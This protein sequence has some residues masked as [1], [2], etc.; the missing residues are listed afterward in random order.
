MAE[1]IVNAKRRNTVPEKLSSIVKKMATSVLR[2]KDASPKAIAI[3]LEM[4]HVAW[5]F[6]DEDY[7]EEPG[8]IHGVREIEES[9]SSLKD[10]FIEDDAEKLIEKLIKH[11]RDKYP[12]DRR[13]IFL[14]EYKDGNIKVNSL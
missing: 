1:L 14:C 5:N 6:A 9:M 4:T 8:Y 10:E 2:K 3:A 13:T 12:K 7:M 11:K